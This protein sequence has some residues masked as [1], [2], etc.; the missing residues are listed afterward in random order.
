[1]E[2]LYTL[3]SL[4]TAVMGNGGW[5]DSSGYHF[6]ES[7]TELYLIV[8][9]Y[10]DSIDYQNSNSYDGWEENCMITQDFYPLED[11]ELVEDIDDGV[12]PMR[13]HGYKS[14]VKKYTLELPPNRKRGDTYTV[15]QIREMITEIEWCGD[16]IP[17]MGFSY[18]NVS[19]DDDTDV[20]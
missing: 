5:M 8:Q 12:T 20:D 2:T 13:A 17:G 19:D 9:G 4:I 11:D 3:T 18:Y 16:D 14:I 1:L 6:N 7:R 15:S 10:G